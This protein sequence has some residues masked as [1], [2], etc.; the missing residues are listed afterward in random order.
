MGPAQQGS[1]GKDAITF[2]SEP[3]LAPH[4]S[5][6]TGGG[7]SNA[8]G[9]TGTGSAAASQPPPFSISGQ[10]HVD[11]FAVGSDNALWQKRLDQDGWHPS[12]DWNSLGGS[13]ACAPSVVAWYPRP[14]VVT[15]IPPVHFSLVVPQTDN[16]IHRWSIDTSTPQPTLTKDDNVSH[17]TF[18]MPTRYTFA[19]DTIQIDNTRSPSSDTDHG[20]G[21][22]KIGGWPLQTKLFDFLDLQNGSHGPYDWDRIGFIGIVELCEPVVYTYSI[23]NNHDV[24]A[25][26]IYYTIIVKALEDSLNDLFKA[27]DPYFTGSEIGAFFSWL[28][29]QLLAVAF[30]GC[31]CLVAAGTMAY[32]TGRDVQDQLLQQG[33]GTPRKFQTSTRSE[34]GNP[35]TT[36]QNSNYLVFTSVTQT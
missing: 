31:D 11:V 12:G 13:L 33:S 10:E 16:T 8:G 24:T 20:I 25:M 22:L 36:C 29:D 28:G 21:T 23:V 15:Q 2:I 32:V 4:I 5:E 27:W 3:V 14:I 30:G 9:T 35:P 18:R 17:P 7:G 1:V 19:L 6:F 26:Q 34:L